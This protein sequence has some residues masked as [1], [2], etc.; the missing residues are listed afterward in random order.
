MWCP[1]CGV[2]FREGFTICSDCDIALGTDPP[3]GEGV[4]HPDIQRVV[5]A[6]YHDIAAAHIAA[7]FLQTQGIAAEVLDEHTVGLNWYLA[8]A[9]GG[10]RLSVD[11]K[12]AEEANHLLEEVALADAPENDAPDEMSYHNENRHNKWLRGAVGL[13]L[14]SPIALLLGLLL[15]NEKSRVEKYPGAPK[16]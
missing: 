11:E 8:P 6:H 12:D 4:E 10:C 5:I 13:L 9:M 1:Q 3:A 16:S 2:E 15:G 14:V 7:D